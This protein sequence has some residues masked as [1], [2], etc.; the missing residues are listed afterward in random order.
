MA[1]SWSFPPF[2]LDEDTGSLWRD[3]T[4]VS[5]PPKA[6]AVL[7]ALVAQA[8]QVVTKEA[9]FAAAWPETAVTD[10]VLKGCIRQIRRALGEHGKTARYIATVHW[11]G[12]RFC[13]PVTPVE[14]SV[15]GMLSTPLSAAEPGAL[16]STVAAS[17][18]F[19]VGREAELARLQ[20]WWAEACQGR[21]QVVFITGEAGIGKTSLV[22]AFVAQ[23]AAAAAVWSARGQCIEHYGVGEAYLP[24]LEALGQLGRG[25]D[26]AHLA[27]LLHQS[28]PTWLVHLPALL[29]AADYEAVQRRAGGTTRERMLRELAE[30]VEVLTT[31][32]P[33]ILILEDLHWSDG[34]TLDWLA[35]MA[36]RRATARLLVLGTYR[37]AEA[38]VQAHPVRRVTQ[39]LQVHGQGMEL[40]VGSLT[41]SAV[42]A[43]LQQRFGSGA[44][45]TALAR[46]LH[47]RTEGNPLFLG[48]VVDAL[49]RQGVVPQGP[50]GWD[51]S[52]GVTAVR[53]AVPESLRQLVEQQLE[54]LPP[55]A[56]QVLEA[57]G[58]V[59][60]EFTAAA[61]AAG[62]EQAVE[63]VEE[64]CTTLA[65]HGQFVQTRGETEWPDGTVTTRYEFRHALYREILYERVQMSRRM[66]WHRQIGLRLETSYGPMARELAA[67]LAEHFVRG[68][69]YERAVPYLRQAGE[70]AM[71]RSAHREASLRYEQAL[72][73][74]EH[75]PQT[76]ETGTQAIDLHLALR[77]ALIPLGDS[78]AIFT[79]MRAAE[80]LAEQ[81]GDLDRQGRIAA[82]WTR[83][84]WGT[85][86]HEQAVVWGQRA[87]TLIRTDAVLRMTVQLYLSY[88]YYHL[89]AYQAA[90]TL[91]TEA[92]GALGELPP[93]ARLGA[94]LPATALRQSLVQSL[95]EL[96][97]FDD[98]IR[99]GQ[100]AIQIAERA[101]HAFSLYQACR[102]LATLYLCQGTLDH[103][104]PLLERT[105]ALCQEADL[106]YGVPSTISRLGLAYA[107][108][109]RPTEALPYLEQT[110]Q[111][112]VAYQTDGGYAMWL[113]LLS[114]SYLLV[115]HLSTAR[116]LAHE[117]LAIAQDRQERGV[118]GYAL[119]LLG[120]LTAQGTDS[121]M[122][123]AAGYYQHAIGLAQE[124][125][126]RPLLAHCHLGVGSL[127]SRL[128]QRA[129]ATAALSTAVEIYRA[130][131]MSFWLPQ[132]EAALARSS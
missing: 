120:A 79:H 8:G 116:S 1:R 114:E 51:L 6:V 85:G 131:S 26:G 41:E 35:A 11:R 117:A 87:L 104:I 113:A 15:P 125:G 102:R 34:A 28:A 37:P 21:R 111:L 119:R 97:R 29:P 52:E 112:A 127:Y 93:R 99:Y 31:A 72:Q 75:L 122:A 27:A 84:W 17:P 80:A 47:Q 101:D 82:Y 30:A 123:A 54:Q 2:R 56:Q 44:H 126:M 39:E 3:D 13:A 129:Q 23:V 130:L 128:G 81:L 50:V 58:V 108:A 95:T 89:G 57:A 62:V 64:W 70:Q 71:A 73:A 69:D 107:Q 110:T 109:G 43:Y 118:Q 92:L 100:E 77:T 18:P 98:G 91:L 66:R 124:L 65:R 12:Y 78:A 16:S 19:L 103:A 46:V 7:A 60:V 59:G 45:P 14:R 90:V 83:D 121:D 5:L 94:A 38:V 132:A 10:G 4:L 53:V 105:L 32:Q 63:Q 61:V 74:L 67:P 20:Q 22:D 9:L 68:R 24:L 88:A 36:R 106:P 42:A 86:H 76:P 48:A 49:V 115:G 96:G 40:P 33:L 25:P 55:E